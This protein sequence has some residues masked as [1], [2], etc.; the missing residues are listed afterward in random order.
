MRAFGRGF[1]Q[2]HEAGRQRPQAVTRLDVAAAQQHLLAPDRHRAHHVE[3][4]FVVHFAARGADRPVAV[5]VGRHA[6]LGRRA[7]DAAMLDAAHVEHAMQFS[8]V[9]C[10]ASSPSLPQGASAAVSK[11]PQ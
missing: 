7:A 4:V 2:F 6:V 1:A 10:M 5:V 3:R 11:D 9:A 8:P